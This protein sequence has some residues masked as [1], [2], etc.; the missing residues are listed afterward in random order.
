MGRNRTLSTL[1]GIYYLDKI[2]LV[3]TSNL[4]FC[5]NLEHSKRAETPE[6][7]CHN[8]PLSIHF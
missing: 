6:R 8:F 1:E 7:S 4:D 2:I 3:L 5:P